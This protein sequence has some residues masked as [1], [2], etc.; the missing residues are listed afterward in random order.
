MSTVHWEEDDHD[1]KI[2]AFL[3]MEKECLRVASEIKDK[4]E[5]KE[6]DEETPFV[7]PVEIDF[8]D[9]SK[10]W[11]LRKYCI[12]ISVSTGQRCKKKISEK[13]HSHCHKHGIVNEK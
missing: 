9:A 1:E 11:A 6:E 12:A 7:F 10:E 13:F 8:D 3:A 5:K 2:L 4:G